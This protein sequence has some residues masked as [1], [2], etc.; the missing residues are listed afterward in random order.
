MADPRCPVTGETMVRDTRP[1]TITY[2]GH[3]TTFD[4]PGWYCDASGE[5]VH[6]GADMKV[7]DRALNALKAHVEGVIRPQE[8]KR[9]RTRLK[10]TQ[11]EAGLLI[12][13]GPNAF[14]KYERG[15]ILT[16]HAVTSALLLLE[17]DPAGLEVL[18]KHRD[19][20]QKNAMQ[21]QP[22]SHRGA[23]STDRA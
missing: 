15:D 7:S 13:G 18:K 9:I 4:M 22:K 12:G 20:A 23:R 14:Q 11:K 16:S 1:M 5:S 3:S 2:K 21:K 17:R 19:M 6:S 10:L 8:V